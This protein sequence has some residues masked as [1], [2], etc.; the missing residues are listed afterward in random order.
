MIRLYTILFIIVLFTKSIESL[1]VNIPLPNTLIF[2]GAS[3]LVTWSINNPNITACNLYLGNGADANNLVIFTIFE[4]NMPTSKTSTWVKIPT[5]APNDN[6]Y[7]VLEG[8]DNPPSRVNV[9]LNIAFGSQSSSVSAV[10]TGPTPTPS[11]NVTSSLSSTISSTSTPSKSKSSSLS[12]TTTSSSPNAP[13]SSE[14]SSSGSNSNTIVGAVVGSIVGIGLV[15]AVILF[16]I[17][18]QKNKKEKR[19]T[20]LFD[21]K[22]ID[23]SGYHED[24]FNNNYSSPPLQQ[25]QQYQQQQ[26]QQYY[27]SQ[28]PYPPPQQSPFIA[29]SE[30]Y[31]MDQMN[32]TRSMNQNQPPPVL[33]YPTK[34]IDSTNMQDNGFQSRTQIESI[35][36]MDSPVSNKPNEIDSQKPHSKY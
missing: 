36:T 28:S 24:N 2:A 8:N 13:S 29:P 18:K 26:H 5:S 12:S 23:F 9:P 17:R 14:P 30:M 35:S 21:D 1:N 31:P 32:Y 27:N 19:H 11:A 15:A 25:H 3:S 34:T 16:C 7:L 4:Q 6:T 20:E 33:A 22:G 10:P